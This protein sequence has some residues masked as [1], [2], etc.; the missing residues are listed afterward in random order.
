MNDKKRVPNITLNGCR[1]IFRN[2]SGK[3]DKFN[4]AGRRSY[5]VLID[6]ELAEELKAGGWNI[7]TLKPRDENEDPQ[8]YL[9]VRVN[10]RNDENTD[11]KIYLVSGKHKT[12]LDAETISSLD[13]AEI[14]NVDVVI[15]PYAWEMTDGKSGITAY[16]KKMYVTVPVDDLD[17]KY[18]FDDEEEEEAP[19]N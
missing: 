15:H 8:P 11:P 17:E 9:Q 18:S 5:C 3:A 19:F 2:F 1:I 13:Y 10:Y 16:T 14:E 12:L 7:K 6:Q 4:P